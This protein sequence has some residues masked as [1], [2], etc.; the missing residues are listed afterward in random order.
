[1]GSTE[2][3]IQ[4][5]EDTILRVAA[6]VDRHAAVETPTK[7][8]L[9]S[10]SV[11][12]VLMVDDTAESKHHDV[13]DRADTVVA[14]RTA[15]APRHEDKHVVVVVVVA[16]AGPAIDAVANHRPQTTPKVRDRGADGARHYHCCCP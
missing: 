4:E 6:A 11:A 14:A 15:M 1:V 13:V 3:S 2:G 16:V 9:P 7:T 10:A 8:L 5:V 12:D